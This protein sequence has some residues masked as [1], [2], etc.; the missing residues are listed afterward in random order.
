MAVT[1]AAAYTTGSGYFVLQVVYSAF[2]PDDSPSF[3][4]GADQVCVSSTMFVCDR[5]YC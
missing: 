4:V 5:P 1:L 2:L 3:A